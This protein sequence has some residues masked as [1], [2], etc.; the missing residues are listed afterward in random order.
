[1]KEKFY[2]Y[3]G[4]NYKRANDQW[5]YYNP[6]YKS[7]TYIGQADGT[8]GPGS[9]SVNGISVENSGNLENY[10]KQSAYVKN[11]WW[12][13]SSTDPTLPKKTTTPEAYKEKRNQVLANPLVTTQQKINYAKGSPLVDTP[14]V[15]KTLTKQLEVEK[16]QKQK[17]ADLKAKEDARQSYLRTSGSDNTRVNNINFDALPKIPTI[18]EKLQEYETITRAQKNEARRIVNSGEFA[19]HF[20]QLKDYYLSKENSYRP[21][22]PLT[23]EEIVLEQMRT[24]PNFFQTLDDRKFEDFKKREQAAYDDMNFLEKGVNFLLATAADPIQTPWNLLT[25]GE[26]PLAYQG[27]MSVDPEL[28]GDD[29]QYY[30]RMTHKSDG[31]MSG[32]NDIINYVN[33]FRSSVSLGHNLAQGDYG[34]AAFDAATIIPAFK[35][36]KYAFK[37]LGKV[38]KANPTSVVS[39]LAKRNVIS[40]STVQSLA[41]NTSPFLKRLSRNATLERGLIGYGGY[42]GATH[43]APEAIKAYSEGDIGKGNEN[44]LMAAMMGIPLL[45][46]AKAVNRFA[47]TEPALQK[48]MPFGKMKTSTPVMS[49][50]E[51]ASEAGLAQASY[52]DDLASTN[53]SEPKSYEYGAD[54]EYEYRLLDEQGKAHMLKKYPNAEQKSITRDLGVP[55]QEGSIYNEGIAGQAQAFED[56]T[57]FAVNWGLKDP[58][59]YKQMIANTDE[60]DN[61]NNELYKLNNGKETKD[62][63]DAVRPVNEAIVQEY[64]N[65]KNI[66]IDEFYMGSKVDTSDYGAFFNKRLFELFKQDPKIAENFKRYQ[67]IINKRESLIAKKDKLVQ[68][69]AA[70]AEDAVDP[71]FKQKVQELYR[72]AGYPEDQIPKNAFGSK[73]LIKDFGKERAYLVEMDYRDPLSEPSFD[74][75]PPGDQMHLANSWKGIAGVNTPRST[76]TLGSRVNEPIWMQVRKKMQP[77]KYEEPVPEHLQWPSQDFNY[78]KPSTWFK[79]DKTWQREKLDYPDEP[80]L[81]GVHNKIRYS[82]EDIGG[83]N[84]HEFGHD[85]QKFYDS[86]GNILTEFDPTL[87]YYTS[88]SKNPIAKRFKDAMVEGKVKTSKDSRGLSY[89]DDTWLSSPNELHSELMK[90]RYKLYT[91]IKAQRPEKS[92]KE[93]MDYIKN[94]EATDNASVYEYY[95]KTLDKHFKESTTPREKKELLKL[96]PVLIP[97][98]GYG[99]IEGMNQDMET[100]IPQNRYGGNIKN[101]SKFIRK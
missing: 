62:A 40:P 74:A 97:A 71:I 21:G 17:E 31:L 51:L 28:L 84:V 43:F 61:V 69:K 77:I 4:L 66:T 12:K 100:E 54:P 46:E 10:F 33:P 50:A 45:G 24:N 93:I 48:F 42:E 57:E 30:D 49:E 80:V 37:N 92:Q 68:D 1:M 99:I 25:R 13:E 73:S 52:A 15:V 76:I 86:W 78:F 98:V 55:T 6:N 63:A 8:G 19:E 81:V 82:P 41:T 90:A 26:G 53:K 70:L 16:I 38:M 9:F 29:Y 89:D 56:S 20:P 34:E 5:F 3:N 64:L 2:T 58:E 96:L 75:L 95:F 32:M 85:Y 87:A 94:A 65:L 91:Q 23:M 60:I 83:V 44:L 22:G 67:D 14:E 7:W 47:R 72:Q 88:H 79:K 59:K 35:A 36:G 18:E 39:N 27:Y 11:D 101:L